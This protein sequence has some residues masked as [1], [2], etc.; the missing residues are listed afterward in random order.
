MNLF[1]KISEDLKAAMLAKQKD[2]LE[3]LRAIKT[4]LLLAKT[5]SGSHEVTP[6]Q[7]M[8][9]LQKMVKQRRESAEIFKTQNRPELAENEIKEA[10]IIEEYLPKQMTEA[11]LI[12]VLKAII[13]RVGATSAKDLGKVMGTA[14]KELAGKADG[15]MIADKVRELLG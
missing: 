10:N 3:S 11:E 9:I 6:D 12:P 8:K 4:A 5:E 13:A 1:D 7:E 15:K 2:R 14:T